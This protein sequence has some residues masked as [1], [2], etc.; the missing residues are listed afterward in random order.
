PHDHPHAATYTDS[1]ASPYAADTL[2]DITWIESIVG[3]Q[4]QLMKTHINPC[5]KAHLIRGAFYL[6]L[7][8]TLCVIPFALAQRNGGT[9]ANAQVHRPDRSPAATSGGVCEA[10]VARYQ[11][12]GSGFDEANAIA[13]D[14]S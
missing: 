11:G 13:V 4:S 9:R 14:G 10:W 8:L 5:M 7:L 2:I 6:L 1:A 12:R 3:F